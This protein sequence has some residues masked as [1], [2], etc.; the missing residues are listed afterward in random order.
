M[1]YLLKI[2]GY[3]LVVGGVWSSMRSVREAGRGP[4]LSRLLFGLMF[5]AMGWWLSQLDFF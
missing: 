4:A 5:I 1:F 3:A 2:L